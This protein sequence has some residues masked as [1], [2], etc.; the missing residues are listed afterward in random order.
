MRN[1]VIY[2]GYNYFFRDSLCNICLVAT[3][4]RIRG[5]KFQNDLKKKT[6]DDDEIRSKTFSTRG[7][8][9]GPGTHCDFPGTSV[10]VFMIY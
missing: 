6:R 1:C 4:S 8:Y 2:F 5:G 7:L 10:T 3:V 9:H